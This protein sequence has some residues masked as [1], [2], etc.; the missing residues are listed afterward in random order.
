MLRGSGHSIDH[1]NGRNQELH[2]RAETAEKGNGRVDDDDVIMTSF[3][4]IFLLNLNPYNFC[5]KCPNDMK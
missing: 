4:K 3:F 2:N 1:S 5:Y